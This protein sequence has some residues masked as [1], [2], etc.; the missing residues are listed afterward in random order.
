VLHTK[1]YS[2]N[3]FAP[4]IVFAN[5]FAPVIA[6]SFARDYSANEFAVTGAN[7]FA[8]TVKGANEFANTVKGANEFA[9]TIM[10]DLNLKTHT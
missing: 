1:N 4:V 7:E 3:L 9:N 2:T 6:N 5:L 10:A 8:N